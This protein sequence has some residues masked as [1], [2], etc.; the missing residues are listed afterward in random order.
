MTKIKILEL[1]FTSLTTG[2]TAYSAGIYQ[3]TFTVQQ[4]V[5]DAS[6]WTTVFG[7]AW[8]YDV[9]AVSIGSVRVDDTILGKVESIAEL[10]EQDGSFYYDSA[11]QIIY[12]AL[13]DYANAWNYRVYKAGETTGFI[14]QAQL[15]YINGVP[16][17]V[18]SYLGSSYYE[19][20]LSSGISASISID[21]Q[22]NGI[23]VFDD[24]T[25]SI[26]NA[27]GKY[28]NI[29]A[30]ITGNE[31]RL[32]TAD[33]ADSKEE[34][35]ATGYPY[36]L[37]A[38]QSDFNIVRLG[39]VEDVDYSD[40]N[41]PKIK[42]IDVR[43]DWS[44]KIGTNFLT[45]SEYP[46][47]EDK[48]VDKRKPILI[49]QVN[50]SSCIQLSEN[51]ATSTATDFL[52][53]DTS[54]GD[55]ETVDNIYFEGQISGADVDRYL[56]AGEYSVNTST[57]ILTINNF[58]DGKA[59][60]YGQ[61]TELTETVEIILFLLENYQN[62]SFINSNFNIAEIDAVKALDY[63]THVYI[64]EKGEKLSAVIEKLVMDI[65]VDF[66]QQGSKLTMRESNEERTA[67]C[68]IPPREIKDNPAGWVNDRTD[69]VKTISVTYN[70]DYRT[71]ETETY[72]DNS[73]EQEAIDNNR[74]AVDKEF[75]TNLTS[76]SDVAAIYDA[77]YSRFVVP[78]RTITVNRTFA[79]SAGLTDFVTFK[80]T[81]VN[82]IDG[83]K[84]V[85]PRGLYK[86]VDKDPINDTLEIIYFRD[87]LYDVFVFDLTGDEGTLLAD[88]TSDNIYVAGSPY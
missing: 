47:L 43:S 79:T 81:R 13:S 50:G 48:Y 55:I 35:I 4:A 56:T 22:K 68:D 11:N 16:Y 3:K 10:R 74:K 57:G 19:P 80:V 78:S 32:L 5:Q 69:T 59:Y 20:R 15:Q 67:V 84:D 54:I 62:L 18:D 70:Q 65:Q 86:I 37:K 34:E 39:V 66:F 40:P 6:F 38:E 8:D 26:N 53:C 49:G 46:D 12:L 83:D 28:D 73:N 82:A 51:P 87:D 42:A 24:L 9:D 77:Y 71:E 25:A 31:A 64:S 29:R 60:F 45:L 72:Y 44:K 14:D 41:E 23:F 27:D 63:K 58:D 2:Y 33:I 17:P 7:F 75:N 88:I 36:K 85:F 30:D 61:V 1:D 76:A 52:I 21:D